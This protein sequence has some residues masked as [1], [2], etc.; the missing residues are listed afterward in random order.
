VNVSAKQFAH[1]SLVGDAQAAIHKAEIEP[2]SLQLEITESM[3]MAD[4][5]LTDRVLVQLKHLGVQIGIDDFGTG[6]SSLSRLRRF[7]VDVIKIDR[8]FVHN[9]DADQVNRDIVNLIVTLAQN[10]NLKAVAEG[11]ESPS[12]VMH[13]KQLQ[14]KFAQGFFFSP[15]VQVEKAE[16]L[17][18]TSAS[19]DEGENHARASVARAGAAG[20]E[21]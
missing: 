17:L 15:P 13:L 3:A 10:L 8:S 1:T 2:S 16:Q 5:D 11:V 12:H 6:H 21:P 7:P 14:C 9:M 19:P 20:T 18:A 4:P